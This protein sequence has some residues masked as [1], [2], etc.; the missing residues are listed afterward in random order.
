MVVSP[1][2]AHDGT[3]R[4]KG[5]SRHDQ[6]AALENVS[7]HDRVAQLQEGP[8]SS[9][10]SADSGVF[11]G[12]GARREEAEQSS[13][14][15]LEPSYESSSSLTAAQ[16]REA[17]LLW[18]D[19][20][21]GAN[22]TDSDESRAAQGRRAAGGGAGARGTGPGGGAGEQPR[23]RRRL[24]RQPE[25]LIDALDQNAGWPGYTCRGGQPPTPPTY[26]A[27]PTVTHAAG[28][29]QRTRPYFAAT[30]TRTGRPR[31][32]RALVRALARVRGGVLAC[33]RACNGS[34]RAHS[35]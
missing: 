33:L 11:P 6:I 20:T 13:G 2:S 14:S 5:R 22:A 29:E 9:R 30:A 24:K 25:N 27:R 28:P 32:G 21:G 3:P 26:P 8:D 10:G 31:T 12:G 34:A 15:A 23:R 7:I 4:R 1:A 19:Q 35:E 18:A 16:R 17:R